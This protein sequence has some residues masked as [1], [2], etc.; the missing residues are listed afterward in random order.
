MAETSTRSRL[1]TTLLAFP[2]PL[3]IFGAH[4]FYIGK[5]ITAIMM[6]ALI[7]LYLV[8]IRF[9]TI[10]WVS[11]VVVVVWSFI[12]FIFAVF[13]VMKDK[14]GKSIQEWQT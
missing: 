1:V 4:R 14:E 6:L 8:T 7:I 13:G 10:V 5:T 3:G 12:D 9:W 11:L 2:I